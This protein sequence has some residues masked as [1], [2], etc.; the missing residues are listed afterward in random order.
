MLNKVPLLII[1]LVIVFII[2]SLL[3]FITM[4]KVITPQKA[5]VQKQAAAANVLISIRAPETEESS[6]TEDI[7][8][9]NQ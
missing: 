6:V 9:S 7:I 5:E 8:S 2:T 3:S 1:I 4:E